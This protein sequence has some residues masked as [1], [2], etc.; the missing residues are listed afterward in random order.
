[1]KQELQVSAGAVKIVS[2]LKESG[3]ESYI[4][5]GAVRDLL[6][7]REPKDFDISTSATPEEI[8]EVF[9]RRKA[10]I[11]GKR[12]RLAHVFMDG[13]IY[14]VSTFRSAPRENAGNPSDYT[15]KSHHVYGAKPENL[16]L[17]DNSFGN[18]KED[19]FRRDFT[20]N[21]LFY[22]PLAQE[23]LDLTGMGMADI[24][25]KTV[26]AIGI[27]ALRFEE[28]P[29]RML[30]ALKLV[31]QFDFTLDN[32]TGNALFSSLELLRHAAT[33]RLTLELEKILK[34]S[35]SDRH[36]EVFHD[37]GLMQY[38]LPHLSRQW[39]SAEVQQMLALLYERNCRVDEKLYRN[40]VSLALAAA[41]LPFV[42]RALGVEVNGIFT[43]P[44]R[45]TREIIGNVVDEVFAP[46]NLMVRVREAAC[47][48]LY[49][50]PALETLDRSRRGEL[51]QQRTYAHAR[52]L[53][54]VRHAATG[55]VLAPLM[56]VWPQGYDHAGKTEFFPRRKDNGK[57][58]EGKKFRRK[59]I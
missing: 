48:I 19:A 17:S 41:A 8:R 35:C 43:L 26:R 10:R 29:V 11:I 21:A 3:F 45:E 20:V 51:M 53:F 46:L 50:Q 27:P 34:S 6:L 57:G 28:D 16:I 1:M 2:A 38:F 14:E 36:F 24:A 23:V 4:V 37:Y 42:N 18:A 54:M 13:E 56:E 39:G 12:F 40:S 5:G 59:K 32:A 30:R 15:E 22:D 58:K 47:R 55:E 9:G 52:E 49:M 33:S 44:G 31:A 25:S 7:G